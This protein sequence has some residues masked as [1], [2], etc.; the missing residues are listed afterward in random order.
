MFRY[1]IRRLVQ[2]I[3]TVFGIYTLT[4]FLMRVLPGD[5]ATILLGFRDDQTALEN[6]RRAMKLDEPILNQYVAFLQ[7]G[8]HGDLGQSYLTGQPVSEMIGQAFMPTIYLAAAA[9]ALAVGVGVPLGVLSAL[10]KNSIWDH[11][12]RLVALVGVS[13]PVFWLG[14]QLQILFGLQLKWLPISGWGLDSH[15]ALPALALCGGTLALLTRMIRS[16]TLEELSQDY[17]RTARSKGL[18]SRT[19]T[20][21]HALRN[22]LLPIITV[23]GGSLANLLSGALLVELI[24]SWP[25]MGRLLIQAITTR[26]YPLLQGLIIVSALLYAGM[27]LLVDL[28]YPFIDPRIRY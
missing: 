11:L 24:F 19:V 1:I 8:L 9:M 22:A 27:N 14:M 5:P 7:N 28:S 18:R 15:I 21:G 13:I 12:S 25:G 17:V 3:P 4:F 2:L 10:R 6:L 20:L 26:D 23:W 16:S